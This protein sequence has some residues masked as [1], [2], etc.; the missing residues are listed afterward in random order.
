VDETVGDD[1]LLGADA[2]DAV[3]VGEASAGFLDNDLGRGVVPTV[4]T[5]PDRDVGVAGRDSQEPVALVRPNPGAP[6]R[7]GRQRV[8]APCQST[9]ARN[10]NFSMSA[11]SETASFTSTTA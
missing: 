2:D 4:P 11:G 6:C 5:G 10:W 3:D 9:S 8:V 1:C 7:N